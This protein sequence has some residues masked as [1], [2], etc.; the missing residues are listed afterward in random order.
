M[1]DTGLSHL[2]RHTITPPPWINYP[3]IHVCNH[4]SS[5]R[6]HLSLT[7]SFTQSLTQTNAHTHTPALNSTLTLLELQQ[8]FVSSTVF[9]RIN[10]SSNLLWALPHTQRS[11]TPG[12]GALSSSQ[13]P[14]IWSVTRCP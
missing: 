5:P 10:S 11:Q 2:H 9:V 12:L 8:D 13:S 14:H 4:T 3:V 7:H 1:T 6:L